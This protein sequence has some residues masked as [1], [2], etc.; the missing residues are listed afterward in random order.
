MQQ[1][2]SYIQN[3]INESNSVCDFK[4]EI[5]KLNDKY[6][7]ENEVFGISESGKASTIHFGYLVVRE[8]LSTLNEA[9]SKFNSRH[10]AIYVIGKDKVFLGEHIPYLDESMSGKKVIDCDSLREINL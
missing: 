5:N 4:N 7:I 3:V 6:N 9:L 8:E 10:D 1:K 2:F